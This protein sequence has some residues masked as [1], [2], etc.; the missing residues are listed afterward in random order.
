MLS[1]WIHKRS[2]GQPAWVGC[3]YGKLKSPQSV[4]ATFTQKFIAVHPLL[5]SIRLSILYSKGNPKQAC[6]PHALLT[7][8]IPWNK[9]LGTL[10]SALGQ[11]KMSWAEQMK[12]HETTKSRQ[13]QVCCRIRNSLLGPLELH[14]SMR[15][16]ETWK[17]E[18][19]TQRWDWELLE[20]KM[21]QTAHS[22]SQKGKKYLSRISGTQS[23]FLF[24]PL[25]PKIK[26]LREINL[27][28]ITFSS[29]Q[30][31]IHV[32]L[33]ATPWITAHQASLSI[34]NSQSLLK[35]MSIELVMPSNYL[36]F[37]HPLLLLPSIFPSIRVFS[38]ESVLRI[39]WPKYW[40]FGI[41]PFNE[42]SGYNIFMLWRYQLKF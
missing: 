21:V 33:F 38:N 10:G 42:Y 15:A 9:T 5:V 34:T 40:S 29:L 32:R 17:T 31:F 36:I 19:K 12:V 28:L 35:L 41:S 1:L 25:S 30:L 11:M 24:P 22:P 4:W 20:L 27:Y 16:W 3:N 7:L 39:R 6:S 2:W 13:A 18:P 26:F 37:C 8:P 23:K 14:L